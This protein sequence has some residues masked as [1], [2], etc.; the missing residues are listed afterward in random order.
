MR[1]RPR[2]QTGYITSQGH[3]WR[4]EYYQSLSQPDGSI[5]RVRRSVVLGNRSSLSTTAAKLEPANTRALP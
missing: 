1:G 5:K 4:G 3:N 2:F